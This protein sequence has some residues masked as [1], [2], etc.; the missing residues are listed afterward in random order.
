MQ[1]FSPKKWIFIEKKL[2]N[3]FLNRVYSDRSELCLSNE[4]III[5]NLHF[6]RKL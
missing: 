4:T 5:Q 2:F 3:I 1:H 6:I